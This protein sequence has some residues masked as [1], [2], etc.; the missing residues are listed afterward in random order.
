MTQKH[1]ENP[2]R[3]L[4][5]TVSLRLNFSWTLL[6]N[7]VS[8]LCMWGIISCYVKIGA[9]DDAGYYVLA[10][11]VVQPIFFFTDFNLRQ[12]YVTDVNDQ[13]EFRDYVAHRLVFCVVG[14]LVSSLIALCYY[15]D[16]RELILSTFLLAVAVAGQ[17]LGEIY[18]AYLQKRDRFDTIA[19]SMML[20]GATS[21][22]VTGIVFAITKNVPSSLAALIFTRFAVVI[23]YDYPQATALAQFRLLPKFSGK[24]FRTLT[25]LG[26]PLAINMG[27]YSFVPQ[28][29]RFYLKEYDGVAV[30]GQFGAIAA[31]MSVGLMVINSLGVAMSQRFAQAYASG[32]RREYLRLTLILSGT[33]FLGTCLALILIPYFGEA[34]LTLAYSRE[35]AGLNDIF[36][37]ITIGTLFGLI[38]TALAYPVTAARYFHVMPLICFVQ[39]IVT[40]AGCWILV[41]D[42]GMYGAT[43]AVGSANA[44]AL[45]C[46]MVVWG[47]TLRR[48][49]KHNA[50][51]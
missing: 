45:V 4:F 39:M 25:L 50:N 33:A 21:L 2:S 17:S 19:G 41:P 51:C 46:F 31:L 8:Q 5:P 15:H 29:P 40:F 1:D 34:V 43:L 13:Y 7:V 27:M 48:M 37:W 44:F 3:P 22:L 16:S 49:P 32:N 20:R 10:L 42:Y 12:V 24:T 26:L 18:H 35:Y 47:I 23:F 14:I 11:A 30:A 38:A 9:A 28:I 36:Y 6:G